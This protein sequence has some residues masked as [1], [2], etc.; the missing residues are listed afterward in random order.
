MSFQSV[1][2]LHSLRDQL[3]VLK[4]QVAGETKA[5]ERAQ[6]ERDQEAIRADRAEAQVR[7]ADQRT[8]YWHDRAER[9]EAAL[10]SLGHAEQM[11]AAH[12]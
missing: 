8:S 5:R 2:E 11:E 3:N 12:G 9:A 4:R 10:R 7:H 6:Y 1:I